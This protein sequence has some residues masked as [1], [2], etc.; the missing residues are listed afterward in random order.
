MMF[1]GAFRWGKM[2]PGVF[3]ELKDGK[4]VDSTVY[5][6]QILKGP[7][8]EFWKESFRDVDELIMMK[9]NAPPHKKVC[10]PVRQE[11]RMKYC[12]VLAHGKMI[13][14][15]GRNLWKTL[16]GFGRRQWKLVEVSMEGME[17][18]RGFLEDLDF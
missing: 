8:Q 16:E 7:L 6:D 14:E 1:W 18:S 10:I 11:L 3:F 2:G 12:N 15:Y 5:R 13:M 9:D 17:T 4:K